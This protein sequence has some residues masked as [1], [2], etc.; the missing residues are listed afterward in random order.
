MYLKYF[1]G[2]CPQILFKVTEKLPVQRREE[3]EQEIL[4][5]GCKNVLHSSDS[6]GSFVKLW[7][8]GIYRAMRPLLL[9]E[10]GQ[11][12]VYSCSRTERDDLEGYW[13]ERE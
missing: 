4:D 9:G 7:K 1:L 3:E 13:E 12:E 11:R 6:E 8:E 10:Y 2:L 5:S